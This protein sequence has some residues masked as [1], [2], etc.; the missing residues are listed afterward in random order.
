MSHHDTRAVQH[1]MN[2]YSW[3]LFMSPPAYMCMGLCGN[4]LLIYYSWVGSLESTSFITHP[5]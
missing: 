4:S 5:Q 1:K 3:R 2:N